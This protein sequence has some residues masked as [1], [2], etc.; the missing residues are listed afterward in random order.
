MWVPRGLFFSLFFFV[1]PFQFCGIENLV[2]LSN[3]IVNEWIKKN[4]TFSHLFCGKMK[5]DR[6]EGSYEKIFFG[7]FFFS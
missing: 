4:P 2:N 5:K 1:A 7:V 3:K 6:L